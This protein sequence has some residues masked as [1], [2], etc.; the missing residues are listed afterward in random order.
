MSDP[1]TSFDVTGSLPTRSGLQLQVRAARPSD[2]AA[3]AEFF[4]HVSRE[5]LRFRFLSALREV[6]EDRL[7]EMTIVDHDRTE[8]LLAFDDAGR[9][10]ASAMIALDGAGETAEVAIAV[11]QD[12]KGRGIGWAL[13][14]RAAAYAQARG[15]KKLQSTESRAN[16]AAIELEREMGFTVHSV[17]DDPS[18]VMVQKLL[19]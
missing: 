6:G 3:L 15:A 11:R 9:I 13:L 14:D 5:D 17:P 10:A 12:L 4:S 7:N 19:Q 8:D 16:H 2:R 1:A 18:V